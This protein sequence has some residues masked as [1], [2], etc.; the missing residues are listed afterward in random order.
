MFFAVKSFQAHCDG[1]NCSEALSFSVPPESE[2]AASEWAI[3]HARFL[4]WQIRSLGNRKG[5]NAYCPEHR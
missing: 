4:G 2:G 5:H 3:R 1:P